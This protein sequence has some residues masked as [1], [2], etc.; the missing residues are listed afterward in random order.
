MH[1]MSEVD[2]KTFPQLLFHSIFLQ[3]GLLSKPRVH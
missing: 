3:Q 1:M 2:V